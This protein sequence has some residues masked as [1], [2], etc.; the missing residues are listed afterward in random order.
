MGTALV[1]L[2][3]LLIGFSADL[4]FFLG[5]SLSYRPRAISIFVVGFWILDLANNTL[6]GPCRALLAD[7]T[8]SLQ[9]LIGFSLMLP[10]G[11]VHGFKL[12][13]FF[14]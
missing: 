10:L 5:D 12:A 13:F 4:G 7:F 11:H 14:P 3:V 8:G 9:A 6:Q 2:A 1:I